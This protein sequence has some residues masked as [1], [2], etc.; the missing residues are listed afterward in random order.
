MANDAIR[1]AK[2]CSNPDLAGYDPNVF[3]AYVKY[4]LFNGGAFPIYS[5]AGQC[6]G[7]ALLSQPPSN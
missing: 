4:A 1:F 6:G 3:A 7:Y 5:L 2:T